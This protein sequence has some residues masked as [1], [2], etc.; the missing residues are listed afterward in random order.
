MRNNIILS[1]LQSPESTYCF[2]VQQIQDQAYTGLSQI[3]LK[4]DLHK[5]TFS[6]Y[7]PK[8]CPKVN[9]PPVDLSVGEIQC[10]SGGR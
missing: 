4:L 8:F 10:E 3:A 2:A 9:E 6:L 7:L 5:S 1:R